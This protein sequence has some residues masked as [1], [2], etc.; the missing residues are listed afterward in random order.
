MWRKG[1]R[2]QETGG[3]SKTRFL[4]HLQRGVRCVCACLISSSNFHLAKG[5]REGARRRKSSGE[6]MMRLMQSRVLLAVLAAL[7]AAVANVQGSCSL[8]LLASSPSK[9]GLEITTESAWCGETAVGFAPP[10]AHLYSFPWGGRFPPSF[11]LSEWFF[12]F[13]NATLGVDCCQTEAAKTSDSPPRLVASLFFT[14]AGTTSDTGCFSARVRH[15]AHC[16]A[17]ISSEHFFFFF[18]VESIRSVTEKSPN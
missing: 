1:T 12:V 13:L 18:F 17:R 5:A 16:L 14:D 11:S 3:V 10:L 8:S 4:F 6:E 7:C 15:A 2:G 9:H